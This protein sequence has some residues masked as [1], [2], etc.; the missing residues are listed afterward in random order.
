MLFFSLSGRVL[1][2]M[3][4]AWQDHGSTMKPGH[5]ADKNGVRSKAV[6]GSRVTTVN[7]EARRMKR[8]VKSARRSS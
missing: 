5:N 2:P 6:W 7:G 1:E 4:R 8:G 3:A